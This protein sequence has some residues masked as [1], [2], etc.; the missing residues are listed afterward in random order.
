LAEWCGQT[1]SITDEGH[2]LGSDRRD[3]TPARKW[4]DLQI[5]LNSDSRF[6]YEIRQVVGK[7]VSRVYDS[8]QI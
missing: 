3:W 4:E 5:Q 6:Q 7:W 8:N 1:H 2:V